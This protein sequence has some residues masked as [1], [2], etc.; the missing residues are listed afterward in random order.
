MEHIQNIELRVG[1]VTEFIDHIPDPIDEYLVIVNDVADWEEIHNYIINDNEI[2]G[3]PNRSIECF[4]LKEYSLRSALYLM[5]YEESELLKTHPK[6][7]NVVFNDTSRRFKR[8][9]TS[10]FLESQESS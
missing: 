8:S 6:I 4:N 2:D 10:V 3:I 9:A 5:S 7:E 1:E